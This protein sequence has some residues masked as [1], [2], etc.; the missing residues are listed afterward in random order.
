M[1]ISLPESFRGFAIS[2]TNE[3]YPVEAVGIDGDSFIVIAIDQR[4]RTLQRVSAV[5]EF[6]WSAQAAI[7][8]RA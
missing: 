6:D 4:C 5:Y 7:D 8:N 3:I 1:F 2:K